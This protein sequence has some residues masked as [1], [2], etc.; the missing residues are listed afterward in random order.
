M[1]CFRL[2]LCFRLLALLLVGAVPFSAR[3]VDAVSRE[4][5]HDALIEVARTEA[6]DFESAYVKAKDAGLPESWLLE[7][8]LVR[9]LSTG[10]VDGML[11]LIPEIDAV[12]DDFRY[13][14]ERDFVSATQ[15]SGFADTLR[16][17]QAYREDDMETFERHAVESFRKAPGFNQAFGIGNLLARHRRDQARAEAMSDFRVPMDMELSNTDGETKT[18]REWMGDDK[19]LLVDFWASWCGPCIYLMPSLKEKHAALSGQ[20]IFVAAVN[21]DS[22][23]QLN[24]ALK[25]REQKG[26]EPVPWLLDRNGSDLS[27]LLMIDSI[28]R[29]VLIDPEGKILYNGHPSSAELEGALAKVGAK[30]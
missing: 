28:P 19:A 20:G 11:G 5:T 15:L 24:N 7:A 8:S 26:M 14:L 4:E 25:V 6:A 2:Y 21:T 13:G 12:E 22:E 29:M 3:A 10:D 27:R 9:M 23:D 17:V 30:L 18:L 1:N 16:C